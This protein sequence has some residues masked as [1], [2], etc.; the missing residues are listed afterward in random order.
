[1]DAGMSLG[2]TCLLGF[3]IEDKGLQVIAT[4]FPSLSTVGAKRRPNHIDLMLG[5]GGHEE[6]RIDIAAVEQVGPGKE[7][8]I[9]QVLLDGGAHDAILHGGR[10]RHH[11]A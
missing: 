9:G 10:C 1:M 4:S 8:A 6:V 7:I 11:L 3:P 5:L 2:A